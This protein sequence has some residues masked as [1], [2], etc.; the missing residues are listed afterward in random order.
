MCQRYIKISAVLVSVGLLLAGGAAQANAQAADDFPPTFVDVSLSTT[1]CAGP[2]AWVYGASTCLRETEVVYICA[3]ILDQDWDDTTGS[4]TEDDQGLVITMLS[5]WLPYSRSGVTYGPEPPAVPTDRAGGEGGDYY[6]FSGPASGV[7]TDV[8]LAFFVPQFNGANQARLRGQIDYDVLWRVTIGVQNGGPDSLPTDED[9]VIRTS[10]FVCAVENSSLAPGNPPPNADAGPDQTVALD[11]TTGQARVKLDGTRTFDGSNIGFSP[12]SAEVF[13]KDIL[14]YTWEWVS[15]PARVEPVEDNDGEPATMWVYLTQAS[16]TT[17]YVYRLLVDDGVNAL[18]STDTVNVWVRTFKPMNRAPRAVIL[19]PD[20]TVATVDDPIQVQVG[21]QVVLQA[22]TDNA[23]PDQDA[24]LFRW[25]QTNEVGGDLESDQIMAGFQPVSGVNTD[26]SEW[27]ALQAGKY[28]FR[29][30]V[31][32]QPEKRDAV[33]AGS[34]KSSTAECCVEVVAASGIAK[35]AAPEASTENG[36]LSADDDSS[37]TLPFA[38][39][40]CGVGLAPLALVPLALGL[41]RSRRR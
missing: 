12:D 35:V 7:T 14:H 39:P 23:D 17:P 26:K 18:P 28:F 11:P 16:T 27:R 37:L 5:D 34:S 4:E 41:M 32:D 9:P 20:G 13:S 8:Q 24:L 15:G 21:E 2:T 29:L 10:F 19:A 31:I 36:T 25:R 38:L 22:N 1:P 30:L 40:Q 3:T 6:F 33:L